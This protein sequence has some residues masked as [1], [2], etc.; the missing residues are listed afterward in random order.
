MST[1][2]ARSRRAP[3]VSPALFSRR[4]RGDGPSPDA[5]LSNGYKSGLRRALLAW[6]RR[7]RRDL[8]WRRTSNPYRIWLSEV[9]LQQTR[10]E[11]ALPYYK[12]FVETFPNV[13]TLAKAPLRRVLALWEGLGYYTRARNLHAAAKTVVRERNGRLPASAAEWQALPGVGR[14]TA[15]AIASI[16]LGERVPVVDGNVKRVIARLFRIDAPIEGPT[17]TRQV[18]ALA[19]Q[20]VPKSAPGDFNQALMELGGRA[21]TPR[22]PE[23]RLCPLRRRCAA[24]ASGVQAKL[25]AHRP[26]RPVPKIAAVAAAIRRNGRILLTRRPPEGLLGGL[27]TLPGAEMSPGRSRA[28]TLRG[29]VTPLGI[30]I[31]ILERI[32]VVRHEFTHRSLQLH[33]YRCERRAGELR[34]SDGCA[35]WVRWERLGD[36]PCATVDRKV[37][38]AIESRDK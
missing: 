7:S 38:A 24:R 25:P 20:L 22:R 31:E 35:R 30:E 17:A 10:I 15:N 2:G 4:E 6:Y 9:L 14:Y 32:A 28:D 3:E 19:E 5:S 26:R 13:R 34:R 37:L 21:C 1:V 36:Y 12:R 27:W 33:V 18:W 16:A 23:C 11:T 8:P 29:A